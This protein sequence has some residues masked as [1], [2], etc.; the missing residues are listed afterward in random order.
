MP[1]NTCFVD[2]LIEYIEKTPV[3]PGELHNVPEVSD[4]YIA[5]APADPS[6]LTNLHFEHAG[7]SY[8]CAICPFPP[9]FDGLH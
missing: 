5:R 4:F 3:P 7:I 8:Y 1:A 6:E 2:T 9:Y